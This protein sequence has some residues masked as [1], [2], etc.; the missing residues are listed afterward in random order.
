MPRI[1]CDMTIAR[2]YRFRPRAGLTLLA[3]A[4]VALFYSLGQWQSGRAQ[5]KLALQ[6]LHD[7]ALAGPP[8][9]LPARLMGVEDLLD[10]PLQVRGRF[11]SQHLLLHDNRVH[12]GQPGYHV[13]MPLLIESVGDGLADTPGVEPV[14]ILVNRGWIA[15]S[16][17]REQLPEIATPQGVVLV[18]GI[19]MLP[20][21]NYALASDDTPGPVRQG[22][23]LARVATQTGLRLQPVMLQQ[24]G[25][26]MPGPGNE[27]PAEMAFA[28]GLARDWPRDDARVDTHRAYALQWYVMA[29][30]T[31]LAW[32]GLNLKRIPD[33]P[34]TARHATE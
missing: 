6:A 1:A 10:Q 19:A 26:V 28:D 34:S 33:A 17:R 24:Q 4:G 29:A 27:Q 25:N 15:A 7:Q 20:K 22:I 30:L 31:L 2:Q 5:Q 11:L 23:E 32:L 14:A 21:L 12:H 9:Q 3:L 8:L 18:R 13:L 16:R